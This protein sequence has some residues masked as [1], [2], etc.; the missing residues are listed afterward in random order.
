MFFLTVLP[1]CASAGLQAVDRDD[2]ERARAVDLELGHIRRAISD[3]GYTL[4]ALEAVMGKGRAYIGK[5]LAGDKPASL[6][7]L[8]LLPYDVQSRLVE[9]R[10]PTY[11][12]IVVRPVTG[13][14]AVRQFV[15]GL[16]GLLTGKQAA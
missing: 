12:L 2:A 6:A 13:H 11:G 9:L 1:K 4:D 16:V 8:V 15:A 7:F 3:C 10:G 5:V 14:D